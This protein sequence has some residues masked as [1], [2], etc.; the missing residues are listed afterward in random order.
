MY[1]NAYIA[2]YNAFI[3][4]ILAPKWPVARKNG[5]TTL[6]STKRQNQGELQEI[7]DGLL[8]LTGWQQELTRKA[9]G[10][11]SAKRPCPSTQKP[12]RRNPP[13]PPSGSD[14]RAFL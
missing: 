3:D 6:K 13:N 5:L 14:A 1:A 7:L 10:I 11:L 12:P 9:L 2:F 8:V 4:G